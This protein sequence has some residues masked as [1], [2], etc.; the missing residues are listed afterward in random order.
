TADYKYA[1]PA[2]RAAG[3]VTVF[4]LDFGG[5]T[6]ASKQVDLDVGKTSEP[7]AVVIGND[8]DTAYVLL[9][10][11]Q[12]VLRIRKLRRAPYVDMVRARTGSE[13]T[14]IAIS[15]TGAKLYVAN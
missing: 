8:D 11:D 3:R 2:T 12:Q 10:N 9:R 4:R 14:G 13:P 15:P 5:A 6:P 7:W 1:V